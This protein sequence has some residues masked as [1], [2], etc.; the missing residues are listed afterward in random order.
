M[1]MI[2]KDDIKKSTLL[3]GYVLI[4]GDADLVKNI[5]KEVRNYIQIGKDLYETQEKMKDFLLHKYGEAW[6]LK[7]GEAVNFIIEN[8]YTESMYNSVKN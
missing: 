6:Y 4:K 2:P 7:S 1:S 3:E 8:E 5:K